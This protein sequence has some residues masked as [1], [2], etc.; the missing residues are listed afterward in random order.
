MIASNAFR[1][2]GRIGQIL[3]KKALSFWCTFFNELLSYFFPY[4]IFKKIIKFLLN[5]GT[6]QGKEVS[7]R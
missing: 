7:H 3:F 5:Q 1:G 2:R 4:N 6:A